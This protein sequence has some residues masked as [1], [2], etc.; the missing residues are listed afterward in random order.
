MKGRGG[1]GR[2]GAG[3]GGKRAAVV[4]AA[5]EGYQEYLIMGRKKEVNKHENKEEINRVGVYRRRRSSQ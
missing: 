2:E 5:R 3:G 4:A 1:E